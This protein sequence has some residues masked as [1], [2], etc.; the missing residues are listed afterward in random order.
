ML[1]LFLFLHF[2][3]LFNFNKNMML[4]H[5]FNSYLMFI[6]IVHFIYIPH[7]LREIKL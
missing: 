5:C 7:S 1:L 2:G 6:Y 3:N 4:Y